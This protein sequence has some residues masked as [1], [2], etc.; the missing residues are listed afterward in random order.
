MWPCWSPDLT[1]LQLGSMLRFRNSNGCLL[2]QKPDFPKQISCDQWKC[3]GL[4]CPD[5]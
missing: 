3:C 1:Y 4:K 5:K 2:I